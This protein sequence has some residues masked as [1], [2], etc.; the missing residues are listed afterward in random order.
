MNSDCRLCPRR[1]GGKEQAPSTDS[2]LRASKPTEGQ[3]W[4]HVLCSVFIPEL[5]F[6]DAARLRN[7]EGISTIPRNRWSERC[8]L[9]SD[10]G[11]AVIRCSDCV[12]E[13]HVSCAWKHGHK[14]GFE[15]Q[16]VKSSRRETTTVASFKGDSGCMNP[17]VFCKEHDRSRRDIYEICEMNET[18]ETA[19]QVYC[20]VYKQAPI[21]Q[22][23]ALLRKAQRLD[24][25]LNPR[26]DNRHLDNN[27]ARANPQCCRC[28]TSYSP[29]FHYLPASFDSHK[30]EDTPE[31]WLC[32]RCHFGKCETSGDPE[33]D[34]DYD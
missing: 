6:T 4:A 14:F 9:C 20:L 7:V 15:I 28:R 24:Q 17:I 25:V 1:K 11:G 32:H 10:A 27:R 12:R 3:N 29:F 13:Y 23:H 21:S 30:S 16:P 19:L 2:F 34:Q 26:G 33:L 18:G 8:C 5:S 22:A 31:S